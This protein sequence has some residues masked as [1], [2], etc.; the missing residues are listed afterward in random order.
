MDEINTYKALNDAIGSAHDRVSSE[1]TEPN[2][3]FSSTYSVFERQ[4]ETVNE[5]KIGIND[6]LKASAWKELGKL[7]FDFTK[8][9]ILKI[10]PPLV[11][12]T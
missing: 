1:R 7:P 9:K 11:K 4:K 3:V 8:S 2:Q 10:V 6:R 12:I 5:E